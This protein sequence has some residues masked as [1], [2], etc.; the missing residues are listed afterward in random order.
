L[1]PGRCDNRTKKR[2]L[3]IQRIIFSRLDA[4]FTRVAILGSIG[5]PNVGD[6][7]LANKQSVRMNWFTNS[8]RISA[9]FSGD[10]WKATPDTIPSPS[11][12]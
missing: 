5:D 9:S 12:Q 7:M 10:F 6:E 3:R 1:D 2:V 8:G 4:G 11:N